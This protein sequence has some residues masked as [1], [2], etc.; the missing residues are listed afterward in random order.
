M[1]VYEEYYA[2]YKGKSPW[3]DD[4]DKEIVYPAVIKNGYKIIK[5]TRDHYIKNKKTNERIYVGTTTNYSRYRLYKAIGGP[6]DGAF[7]NIEYDGEYI[8]F[9]N[10]T[11]KNKKFSNV[12]IHKSLLAE[13]K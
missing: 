11:G 1:A 8:P 12:L 7:L 13:G 3:I 5:I 6:Q 2:K 9:N 10:A 4:N